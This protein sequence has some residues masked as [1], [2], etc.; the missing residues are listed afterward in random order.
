MAI[1]GT[2]STAQILSAQAANNRRAAQQA[3]LVEPQQAQNAAGTPMGLVSAGISSIGNALNAG[4]RRQAEQANNDRANAIRLEQQQYSR[5]AAQDKLAAQQEQTN[6]NRGQDT[7]RNDRAQASQDAALQAATVKQQ[8][9]ATNFDNAQIDRA[10]TIAGEHANVQLQSELQNIQ[11]AQAVQKAQATTA[12]GY[13]PNSPVVQRANDINAYYAAGAAEG[14]QANAVQRFL[15]TQPEELANSIGG[16][17]NVQD[18]VNDAT[19][20]YL[21]KHPNTDPALLDFAIFDELQSTEISAETWFSDAGNFNEEGFLARISK[22]I[23]KLMKANLL[24][25]KFGTIDNQ[26]TEYAAASQLNAAGASLR[27]R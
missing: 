17:Q 22:K 10:A 4:G 24:A 25:S 20:Q 11:Q 21:K 19:A 7:I 9:S 18:D 12:L 8:Q 5:N 15:K 27:N 6:Y 1:T 14:G 13:K 2:Q 16:R 3:Q 26:A 23:P